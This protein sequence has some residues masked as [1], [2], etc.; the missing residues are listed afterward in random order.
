[1]LSGAP[2]R[3]AHVGAV[4][5]FAQVHQRQE[6]AE[7]ARL[8]VI[9]QMQAAGGNPRQP[10]PVLGNEAHDFPLPLVRRVSQ[11]RFAAHLG[12][13]RFERQREM[14]NAELL[15][16]KSRRALVLATRNLARCGHRDN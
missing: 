12:T 16:R 7:D 2:E 13:T 11:G 4:Q 1:M 6:R 15:F 3:A 9:G 8:Q 10:L 5:V 14:Q